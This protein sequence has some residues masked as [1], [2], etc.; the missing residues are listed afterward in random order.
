[1]IDHTSSS[2]A[3]SGDRPEP[4]TRFVAALIDGLVASLLGGVPFL[5]ALIGAGYLVVRDGMQVGALKYRSVGKYV[6]GLNVVRLD[7]RT[8]DIEVSVQRN[9]MFGIGI[10]GAA[11]ARVPFVG[12][13]LALAVGLAAVALVAYE[14]YNVYTDPSGRRWGDRLGNTRVVETGDGLL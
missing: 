11:V 12:G 10:V 2:G 6:M 7:G 8:M 4:G 14:V 13:I 1:M 3:A 5:G 9:W